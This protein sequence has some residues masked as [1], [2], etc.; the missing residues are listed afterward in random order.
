MD[1]RNNSISPDTLYARPGSEAALI[2]V[3]VRRNADFAGAGA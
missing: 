1:H 3:D 2:F